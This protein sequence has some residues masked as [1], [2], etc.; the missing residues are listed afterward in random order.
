MQGANVHDERLLLLKGEEIA[1]RFDDGHVPDAES[2][3]GALAS[4]RAEAWSGVTV[5]RMEPFDSLL[6]WLAT[7]LDGFCLISVDP[8]LDS[9]LVAPQN[10]MG[11]PAMV[12]GGTFAYLT[13]R[14]VSDD[15]DRPLWEFGAHGFGPDADKLAERMAEQIRTWNS[16]HRSGP[17]PRIAAYPAHT[18]DDQLPEG[19]VIDKR[20][21]RLTISWSTA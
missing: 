13:L 12:A 4:L 9:G 3:N 19:T 7:A 17:G 14:K 21:V 6:L 20:H 8:E 2:L 11:S 10:K 5:G 15:P 1:L 18:P 16:H